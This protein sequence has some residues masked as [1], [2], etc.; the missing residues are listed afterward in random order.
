MKKTRKLL[1]KLRKISYKNKKHKYKLKEPFRKRRL[2]IEEGINMEANKTKK[3]RKKAAIAKKGRFNILRIYRRYKKI[4]E[5]KKFTRDMR[6]IDKKYKLGKTRNICGKKKK[7]DSQKNSP[8]NIFNKP[9]QICS[10]SPMTGFN[11]N[12]LCTTDS[13]DYGTHLVCSE[14]DKPFLD[15]TASRGNDL[16]SVV[17]EGD[18]WCLCQERWLEAYENNKAPTVIKNATNNKT[19]RKVKSII[20]LKNKKKRKKIL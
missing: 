5:C 19:R 7:G 20:L 2:A 10:T 13:R 17:E 15:F 1:P 18:R 6:Y 9:L 11:R 3:S 4:N 12:G 8:K 14:M 16:T